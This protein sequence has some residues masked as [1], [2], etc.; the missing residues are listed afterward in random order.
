MNRKAL[1]LMAIGMMFTTIGVSMHANGNKIGGYAMVVSA[2]LF[3]SSGLAIQLKGQP[4]KPP[5]DSDADEK[6]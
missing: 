2:I 6:P 5:L 4:L 1:S 3:I